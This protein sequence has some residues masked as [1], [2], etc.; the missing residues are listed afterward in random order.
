LEL[1]GYSSRT[2]EDY[3][4]VDPV[5][6]HVEVHG[7]PVERDVLMSLTGTYNGTPLEDL[8]REQAAQGDIAVH[9]SDGPF[10]QYTTQGARLRTA[11]STTGLAARPITPGADV[12]LGEE[13]EPAVY[14]PTE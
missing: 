4:L 3:V 10:N 7:E 1:S 13:H 11:A 5:N 12:F 6:G 8:S 2:A 14:L 9:L